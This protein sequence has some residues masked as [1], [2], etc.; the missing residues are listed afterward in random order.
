MTTDHV[1][2]IGRLVEVLH[3]VVYFAPE[4]AAAYRDA[5]LTGFWRG[6][7]G[8][9]AAPLGRASAELVTA[10]F[11]GFAPEMVARAVPDVWSR[12]PPEDVLRARS[13]GV[14]AAL[15]R[16]LG[17]ADP[18]AGATR[19]ATVV[20][21]LDI[22]DRPMAA[23]QVALGRPDDP[24]LALW[25]HGTV[26]REHRGDG[27]LAV[28]TAAG[29]RWPEPHLLLGSLGRLDPRQ[30]EYRGWSDDAWSTAA[31][32]LHERGWL[33]DGRPTEVGRAAYEDL[34]RRT[35]DVA[36]SAFEGVDVE[37][38]TEVLAPLAARVVDT[39]GVPF[40]NAM[41]LERPASLRPTAGGRRRPAPPRRGTTAAGA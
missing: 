31:A 7:F 1:R 11:G 3:A 12:L 30:Q 33:D 9:R 5:G 36:A 17:D 16:L 13:D 23:A 2:R 8:G 34:E 18:T 14:T 32:R 35:D 25:H 40:P 20:D 4:V 27:H 6:Y 10:V 39:G 24:L 15:R 41:G 28:V 22:A 38:L 19:L 29:L 26:L 21:A 37:A